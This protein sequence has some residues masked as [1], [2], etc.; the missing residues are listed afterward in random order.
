MR[1]SPVQLLDCLNGSNIIKFSGKDHHIVRAHSVSALPPRPPAPPP[2]APCEPDLTKAIGTSTTVMS[3][4]HTER[5]DGRA[6]D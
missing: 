5:Q 3:K 6:P 2:P 4:S 1:Y